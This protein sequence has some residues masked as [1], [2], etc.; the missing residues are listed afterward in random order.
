MIYA[1]MNTDLSIYPKAI[2]QAL[3]FLD[4]HDIAHMTPG[5]YP[6]MQDKMFAVVVD[7]QLAET[8]DVKPE[9]HRTY[10]DV[11]YWPEQATRFGVFPLSEHSVAM[12]EH[13]E[14]DV[15]YYQAEPDESFLIGRPNH[16]AVFFPSDVHRPDL[17]VHGNETIR[18]CVV[19]V[20][21][22]LLRETPAVEG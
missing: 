6:I 10:I 14:N 2:Q 4:G 7:V 16:F 5:K 13:P 17:T 12:E 21:V 18:K 8:E 9:A 1:G 15:W 11:Q 22:E 19:K 3:A 20:A